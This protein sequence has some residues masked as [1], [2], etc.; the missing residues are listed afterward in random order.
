MRRYFVTMTMPVAASQGPIGLAPA[1]HVTFHDNA[2]A[3]VGHFQRCFS[4]ISMGPWAPAVAN[5][6]LLIS[7]IGCIRSPGPCFESVVAQMNLTS[8]GHLIDPDSRLG[9]V[10]RPF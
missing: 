8:G 9:L 1:V 6:I 10:V 4:E 7:D 3:A 2:G 5:G